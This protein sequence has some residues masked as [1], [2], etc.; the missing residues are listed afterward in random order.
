MK[1]FYSFPDQGLV[2]YVPQ[3]IQHLAIREK[4][5]NEGGKIIFYYMED[6]VTVVSQS[7]LL[8]KLY[9][10]SSKSN[11]IVF[12]SLDQFRYGSQLN[13]KLLKTILGKKIEIHFACENYCILN[14]DQFNDDL[15]FL[16]LVDHSLRFDTE[17]FIDRL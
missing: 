15:D 12:F 14:D 16:L 6:T 5:Q 13:L 17:G 7:V 3:P 9:I 8:S 1:K 11:G 2:K 10:L 4:A